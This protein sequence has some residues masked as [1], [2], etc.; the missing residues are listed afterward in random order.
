MQ[1]LSLDIVSELYNANDVFIGRRLIQDMEKSIISIKRKNN[2]TNSVEWLFYKNKL[3]NLQLTKALKTDERVTKRLDY[4]CSAMT[5][6]KQLDFLVLLSAQTV[7]ITYL[8]ETGKVIREILRNPK[9]KMNKK[10]KKFNKLYEENKITFNE[11]RQS[12]ASWIG[13]AKH[14]NTYNL[15]KSMMKKLKLKKD[16]R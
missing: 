3:Y 4:S 14:G 1:N 12:T 7:C 9:S 16:F 8:T 2:Y 15:R 6:I 13:H 11:I 10:I 5:K